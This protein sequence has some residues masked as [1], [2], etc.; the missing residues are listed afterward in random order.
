M[1]KLEHR[2]CNHNSFSEDQS[3]GNLEPRAS[4]TNLRA[5]R[6][7]KQNNN[8][9]SILG[10]DLKNTAAWGILVDTGAAVSLAPVSFAPETELSPLE[11][12][13]QLKTVTGKEI[14]AYGRKTVHLV[15]RELSFAISFVIADVEHALLGL[16]VFLREQL[17]MIWG[18]NGE[19]NLV[20][21]A[22]AKTKLQQRGHLLYIEACSSKLG[23]STCRGSSLPQTDGSLLDD[24]NETQPAAALQPELASQEVTS[25]GGAF[26]SSFSLENLRQHRNTTSLGATALPAKGAKKRNKKKKPSARGAS[27]NQLDE[28][29]SKQEGQQP[30]AAQLRTWNKTSLTAE[31]ELA[32][33]EEAQASLNKIDQQELCLRILLILS[34]RYKWQIVTTRATTACS[35]ELLGQQLRSIGLDQNKLDRNIF[36]GDELVVML[37]KN[38]LLIGGTEPQQESFYTELSAINPLDQPTKL[39]TDTQVSLGH[40]TLEYHEASN[41]ISMS[42]HKSFCEKLWQRHQLEDAEPLTNLDSEKLCQ[43]ASGQLSALDAQRAELYRRSVGDLVL[44][45]ACRP[46]LGFEVHLLTQ[47]LPNPTKDQEMQLHKVLRYLKGTWHYTLSLHPTTQMTQERA[48]N[49]NLVAFSASSWTEACKSTSTAYVTLWGAHVIASLQTCCAYNQATAEL[50]SVRLALQLAC[51]TKSLLQQ[52]SVEQLAH[53]HVN[54]SLRISS[55]HDELVTGR[56]LAMQLGLSRKNKRIQLRSE[57]GQLHLCKVIPDKNLACSLTNIASDSDRMLAK[58]RVFTGAAEIGAL[59]TVRVQGLAS[60]G[61]SSSLVGGVIA[62]TPAMAS[63]QLRQLDLTEPDYESFRRTS[64]ARSSLTLTSLSL[65]GDR[66]HSLT[67]TSLSLTGDRFHSLTLTSL[68]LTGDRFHSL[69]LTSLSLTGDR[70]PSLTL[71]SLSPKGDRF[72]SLTLQSLSLIAQKEFQKASST[73]AS[74][75]KPEACTSSTRVSTSQLVASTS[76]RR[77][78]RKQLRALKIRIFPSLFREMVIL[79]IHSL[80]QQLGSYSLSVHIRSLRSGA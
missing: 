22:G 1:K 61:C 40:R 28:N 16:D 27:H 72:P 8:N 26:G 59:F 43:D 25:S 17:S 24:K 35:E 75:A 6:C 63:H 48:S 12:T 5:C 79:M 32:A 66:F 54:I 14:K 11:S 20:N 52:L 51:R 42:L 3:L 7:P 19:I 2:P 34:L 68:S 4:T 21:R 71:P 70:F 45:A 29:S 44:A 9:S 58:L 37:C 78:S 60:F 30:A 76:S 67:L 23:L 65:T 47:S 36:S 41:S 10:Q 15:G 13:L 69:T 73:R 18:S 39:A 55:W 31:I 62:E 56:P 77:A 74:D 53:K 80:D 46:D 57:N 49:L 50:D 33:E 38:D 64:F